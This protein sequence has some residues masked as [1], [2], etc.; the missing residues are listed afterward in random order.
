[1]IQH[2]FH[3]LL[4]ASLCAWTVSA[5][6]THAGAD[7]QSVPLKAQARALFEDAKKLV[8][9]S[10]HAEA[11][12]KFEESQRLD[13]GI[14]TKFYLADC[15]EHIGRYA[16]AWVLYLEVADEAGDAK[17]KEREEYARKRA[18]VLQP[19]LTR[20]VV[21]L[22]DDVKAI[23]GIEVRRDGVVLKAGQWGAPLPVDPGKHAISVGAPSKR[24]WET[25]V[26]ASG[27]GATITV[28]IPML[29]YD[30]EEAPAASAPATATA[31]A[32]AT[33][34]ATGAAAATAGSSGSG[35]GQ[36]PPPS[37]AG[38]STQRKVALGIGAAGV[39]GLVF[40]GVFGGL[41]FGKADQGRGFCTAGTNGGPDHCTPEGGRLLED[42]NT[43]ANVANAG[44]IGG[45]VLAAAGVVLWLVAPPSDKPAVSAGAR[46]LRVGVSAGPRGA[47]FQLGREW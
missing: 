39:A 21:V 16:S 6:A 20:L 32:S 19:K 17:M 11:C 26:E 2:R 47:V 3:R 4:C 45:G 14:G 41:A 29:R 34:I 36:P 7:D 15:L 23:P 30:G 9:Q 40:G 31:I 43:L 25:T 24:T 33:A 37:E 1:M 22:A 27:E 38:W 35:V 44:L 28:T 42:A 12:P 8:A 46:P 5:L 13:P 18:D 10:R